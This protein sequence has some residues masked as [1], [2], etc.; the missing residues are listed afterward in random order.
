MN[1]QGRRYVRNFT[2]TDFVFIKKFQPVRADR[3]SPSLP[4]A[5]TTVPQNNVDQLISNIIISTFSPN[6]HRSESEC[7]SHSQGA[8]F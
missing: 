5:R 8:P 7:L 3:L 4:F 2:S 1:E 6:L